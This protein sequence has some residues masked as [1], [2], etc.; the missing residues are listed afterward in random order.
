MSEFNIENILNNVDSFEVKIDKTKKSKDV[1]ETAYILDDRSQRIGVKSTLSD[2]ST[3]VSCLVCLAHLVGQNADHVIDCHKKIYSGKHCTICCVVADESHRFSNSHA[4]QLAKMRTIEMNGSMVGLAKGGELVLD[5]K[6]P[7]ITVSEKVF[8][9][10]KR[11]KASKN[12]E[13]GG[14]AAF[15]LKSALLAAATNNS[16]SKKLS[17]NSTVVQMLSQLAIIISN[18]NVPCPSAAK[19]TYT[20]NGYSVIEMIGALKSIYEDE[21][22]FTFITRKCI[23]HDIEEKTVQFKDPFR[24][25]NH[26]LGLLST[27]TGKTFTKLQKN[28][29]KKME[30]Q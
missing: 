3:A 8:D 4:I 26:I 20:I 23:L 11:L 13:P 28:V 2:G 6:G 14:L 27:L 10:E 17:E 7:N 25:Y 21:Y 18:G 12:P 19:I 29:A 22:A 5:L 16:S 1:V 15:H 24:S 30:V 9:L